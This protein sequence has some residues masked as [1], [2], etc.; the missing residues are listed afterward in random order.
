METIGNFFQSVYDS[1]RDRIKSPFVGSFVLSFLIF[2]WQVFAILFYSEWPLHCRIE[3]IEEHFYKESNVWYPVL[4]A[5]F[6]ILILPYINLFFD[7]ILSIYSNQKL[8]K[9][10]A[11]RVS[12]LKTQKAEAKLLREIADEQA[13][14]S[15][16]LNLQVKINSQQK[17]INDLTNQYKEDS[18]R[19]KERSSTSHEI[20]QELNSKV[21]ELSK[22]N[23]VLKSRINELAQYKAQK[24][25]QDYKNLSDPDIVNLALKAL[26]KTTL[27]EREAF[28]SL[29]GKGQ[30]SNT[31]LPLNF[32][33]SLLSRLIDL[34][35]VQ[36]N[37]DVIEITTLGKFI[38]A[39]IQSDISKYNIS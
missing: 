25:E 35:L 39:L 18:D 13:G 16:I 19:W 14:T 6:Y 38:L 22:E 4:I 27:S 11:A 28:M 21:D 32:D 7:W 31:Y 8:I 23:R 37:N 30:A 1:Y 24:D 2:N 9:K 17:E 34:G 3:W 15:E 5:L 20:E 26:K 33:E 29:F 12:D 10:N 36:L